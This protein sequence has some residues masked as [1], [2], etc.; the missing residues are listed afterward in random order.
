MRPEKFAIMQNYIRKW[1][2]WIKLRLSK[3]IELKTSFQDLGAS[4]L[5]MLDAYTRGFFMGL[6]SLMPNFGW[7]K[8]SMKTRDTRHTTKLA[9]DDVKGFFANFHKDS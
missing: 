4:Y 8:I 6:L 1:T 2:F 9:Q 3:I 5:F 7:S